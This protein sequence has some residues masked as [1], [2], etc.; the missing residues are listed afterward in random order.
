V[1]WAQFL[2]YIIS[3]CLGSLLAAGAYIVVFRTPADGHS[4]TAEIEAVSA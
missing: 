1:K 4:E 2:I 3:E